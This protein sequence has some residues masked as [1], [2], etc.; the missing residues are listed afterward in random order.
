MAKSCDFNA[1]DITF[2]DLQ[3]R[4]TGFEVGR[5]EAGKKCNTWEINRDEGFSNTREGKSD[6]N[7]ARS[8]NATPQAIRRM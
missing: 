1:S 2:C 3:I 7:S 8:E 5:H 6:L 4:L